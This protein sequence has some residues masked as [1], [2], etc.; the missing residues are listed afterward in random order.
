MI[1]KEKVRRRALESRNGLDE[2]WRAENSKIIVER[3]L[4]SEMYQRAK[5]V[6]SYSTFRS[7]VETDRLNE[8]VL[9][10]GKKLYLPRVRP[11]EKQMNFY[12]VEDLTKRIKGYQG[13]LE[14]QEAASL[15]EMFEAGCEEKAEEI[16]MVMPGVSFDKN[17]NRMGYGGGYYDRYLERYADRVTT[18]MIAFDEQETMIIPAERCDIRPQY[19][20]TQTVQKKFERR[21]KQR[22]KREEKI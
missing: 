5:I 20:F 7:E 16:L 2:D 8:A 4:Q 14:P 9:A 10:Q 17:G 12:P 15:E 1:S 22:R 11:Q 19:I 18:V 3:V 13:I 21:K 6:L